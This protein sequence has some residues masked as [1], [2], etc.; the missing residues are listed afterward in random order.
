MIDTAEVV[1]ACRR[2]IVHAWGDNP[3]FRCT[4]AVAMFPVLSDHFRSSSSDVWQVLADQT[5]H[6]LA[7]PPQFVPSIYRNEYLLDGHVELQSLPRSEVY[8]GNPEALEWS[9]VQAASF[10]CG[11]R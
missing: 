6:Q 3:S 11:S 7:T 4:L 2:L 1:L 10:D 8:N 5:R 9:Q